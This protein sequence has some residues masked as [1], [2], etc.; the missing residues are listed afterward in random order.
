MNDAI[1]MLGK[2]SMNTIAQLQN[3][4]VLLMDLVIYVE[5]QDYSL[6]MVVQ[7]SSGRTCSTCIHGTQLYS[8][9]LLGASLSH[10]TYQ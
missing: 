8:L 3:Q 4:N 2:S 1:M 10:V 9:V 7:I 5:Y 6:D